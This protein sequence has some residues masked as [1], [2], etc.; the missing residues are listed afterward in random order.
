[1]SDWSE[2]SLQDHEL[3]YIL[4]KFG[5][6]ESIENRKILRDWE[7]NFKDSKGG[8]HTKSYTKDEFYNYLKLHPEFK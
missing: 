3:D 8:Q 5:Y 2:L 1:M 6:S 7:R 4:H